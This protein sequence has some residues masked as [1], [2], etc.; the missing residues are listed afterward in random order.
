MAPASAA[1][2]A[3]LPFFNCPIPRARVVLNHW[4]GYKSTMPEMTNTGNSPPDF[5]RWQECAFDLAR[6]LA[7]YSGSKMIANIARVISRHP[8]AAIGNAFNKKQIACKM[9]ARDKLFESLGGKF[10][11]IFIVGGWY[12]V[13]AAMVFDDSRFDVAS[14]E[15]SDI[16][17]AVAAVAHT[18]NGH[19]G[20]RFHAI[21]HDMYT[22]D[23]AKARPDLVINTS[24]EHIADLR[25]WLGLLPAGTAVLLQ[26]NNY[27]SEPGHI[28]CMHS[29]TQFAAAAQ[30]A[31]VLY[32]GELPAKNYTRFMLI[33]RV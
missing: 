4:P 19:A 17:P 29:L 6:G 20:S 22:L 5:N 27:F 9:W 14:C 28:S 2:I 12:A 25:D 30:L 33:G 16:D 18:L 24:C 7:V 10:H 21:T 1:G 26:S 23:Y 3:V 31:E 8:D 11:R 15:S 32:S 13:L